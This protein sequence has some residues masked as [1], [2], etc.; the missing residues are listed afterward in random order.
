MRARPF[1][2]TALVAG[3][4]LLFFLLPAVPLRGQEGEP[5]TL[6]PDEPGKS[7]GFFLGLSARSLTFNGDLD[8]KLILWHF[9][10]AFF[11]P[12]LAPAPGLGVGF[13]VK[14]AGWLW[15][16]GYVR[17]IHDAALP[18]R[19]TR[20]VYNSIEINGKSFLLKKF[21]L[22]P[23]ISLGISVPWLTVRDGSEF[24]GARMNASYIGIGLQAGAGFVVDISRHFFVSG[25][26]GARALGYY[27]ASGE[28]RGRDITELHNGYDGP[29]WKN[30]LRSWTLG[31]VFGLGIVL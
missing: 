26:G 14:H 7:D 25:G 8:G 11:S 10:K 2:R 17:S 30:W 15:E 16:M 18:D 6:R 27:Y 3:F 21:P 31:V 23:Y 1:S 12:K 19:M 29:A 4:V 28:G 9:E 5:P 13:G 20:A 22:Q 24:A